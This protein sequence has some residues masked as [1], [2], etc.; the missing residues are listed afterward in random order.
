MIVVTS[1]FKAKPGMRGKVLEIVRPCIEATRKETGCMRYELFMASEDDVTLQF[2]EEW[3]DIEA[4]RAH[5]ASPHLVEY[6]ERR[7]GFVE[8]EGGVLKIF[9]AAP[10][11]L[12]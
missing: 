4:L 9:E 7:K 5:M 2:I 8:E 3:A 1:T 6:R 11:S 10:V 12:N